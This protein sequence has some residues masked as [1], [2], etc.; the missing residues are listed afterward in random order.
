MLLTNWGFLL[1]TASAILTV[2]YPDI[3]TVYDSRVCDTLRDFHN[4][5][6]RKWSSK[7]WGE[8]QRFISAVRHAAPQGLTLRDCDRWL[9][10]ARQAGQ[11]A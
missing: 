4:L 11:V 3:F 5:G 2:L 6:G 9:S 7:T 10:G 8:Y 1:P